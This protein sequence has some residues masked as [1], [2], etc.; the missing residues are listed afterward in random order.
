MLHQHGQGQQRGCT[1]LPQEFLRCGQL[2]L[3]HC[4]EEGLWR[5]RGPGDTGHV[6]REAQRTLGKQGEG[7]KLAFCRFAQNRHKTTQI[8]QFTASPQIFN[9]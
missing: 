1:R 6:G 7:G 9:P 8:F 2:V 4:G 5:L 3:P